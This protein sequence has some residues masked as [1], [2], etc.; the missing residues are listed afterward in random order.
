MGDERNIMDDTRG[1]ETYEVLQ[2][3]KADMSNLDDIERLHWVM[4]QF[5]EGTDANPV[6]DTEHRRALEHQELLDE[7]AR[8]E[9]AR[10]EEQA[11]LD[12][13]AAAEQARR[14][15]HLQA[16]MDSVEGAGY[17][18][19]T[20]DGG[21]KQYFGG[22][23]LGSIKFREHFVWDD[24][25]K[26]YVRRGTET[27]FYGA[28]GEKT[29]DPWTVR[30]FRKRYGRVVQVGKHDEFRTIAAYMDQ[31]SKNMHEGDDD[32][33]ATGYDDTGYETRDPTEEADPWFNANGYQWDTFAGGF[34]PE[35]GGPAPMATLANTAKPE[36]V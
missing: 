1:A 11:R 36:P 4:G 12:A 26:E 30:Q 20:S 22:M 33:D 7:L 16:A 9:A 21:P 25:K 35:E 24:W 32:P 23:R 18:P 19:A 5:K 17:I 15:R 28:E 2:Q 8:R 31:L 29:E 13:E 6:F 27:Q 10:A 3:Q 14:D 34:F